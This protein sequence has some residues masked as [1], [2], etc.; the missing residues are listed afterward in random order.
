M[1]KFICDSNSLQ[2]IDFS[3]NKLKTIPETCLENK[4]SLN[5][6]NLNSNPLKCDCK[7]NH[8]KTWLDEKYKI[9]STSQD[10]TFFELLFDWRCYEPLSLRD[11]N[12][13]NLSKSDLKCEFASLLKRTNSTTLTTS[14]T[15]TTSTTVT[16]ITSTKQSLSVLSYIINDESLFTNTLSLSDIEEEL[17]AKA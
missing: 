14:M 13:I 16:L 9:N 1:P 2:E 7:L 15:T 10:S 8:L 6:L 5:K 12:F 4:N 11:R 17:E 3:Y